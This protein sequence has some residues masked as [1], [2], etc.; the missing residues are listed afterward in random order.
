MGG[1]IFKSILKGV[2][3]KSINWYNY[4]NKVIWR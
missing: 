2:D 4:N 3:K 1:G